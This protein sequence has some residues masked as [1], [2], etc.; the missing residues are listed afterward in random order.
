M[1]NEELQFSNQY[2]IQWFPGHMARTLRVMEQEIQHVD[3]SLILLDARI[4]LS[5]LNP[6]VERITARKPRLYALNKAD[7]ADPAVTEE[8]I[9]YFRAAD[10][11]CV[12]INAK[13]KGGTAAV[14]AAIEKEL[15]GL[16][17]R[18][19]ARGMS[20][21]K[22]QIMLCG[23]PNVGKSTFI[24]K[25]A[26]RKSAKASDRPGVTRGKQWVTMDR[27]L[28]LLDTPGI[29]WPKFEDAQTGLHLAF[30]GAVKDEIM[31]V[32]T[33]GCHLMA[34]LGER[35]PAAL[36]AYKLTEVPAREDGEETV[37]YGYRLLELAAGK[38]GMRISGG[39]FYTERMAR[40]LLDEF[41]GGKLGKFTLELPGED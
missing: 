8:W 23:I 19:Q 2:N 25:V 22:T 21:A 1:N 11:G 5:S 10:A 38:R 31:D 29:L 16:L 18:R 30:T 3:A 6:E 24:N 13:S 14:R 37:A 35:Y 17:A 28:E 41:R 4:P 34:F 12:A 32:E 26:K 7:L 36:Q 39:E 9:R 27:G 20:G 40:V 15:S 33:L